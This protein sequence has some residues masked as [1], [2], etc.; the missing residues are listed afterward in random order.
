MQLCVYAARYK[1]M[2]ACVVFLH[3]CMQGTRSAVPDQR[4]AKVSGGAKT[5]THKIVHHFNL[6]LHIYKC[7]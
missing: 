1:A 5:Q 3:A 4:C 2:H 6:H 7:F